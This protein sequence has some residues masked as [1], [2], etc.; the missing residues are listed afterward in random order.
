MPETGKNKLTIAVSSCLLGHNVRYDGSNK[1]ND[2]V[3]RLCTMFN[4]LAICPEYSIGM[5]VP[6]SPINLVSVNGRYRARGAIDPEFDVTDL[7]NQFAVSIV[8][9]NPEL[10]GY[11]FKARSPSCGLDSTPWFDDDSRQ[12]GL[13]SGIFSHKIHLLLP[14]LP[15]IEEAQLTGNDEI[16]EFIVRAKNYARLCKSI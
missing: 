1:K 13:T 12:Q 9:S 16:E 15:M 2:H 14:E 10:C 8:N 11:V 5:G 7:L 4:C 6:R 3:L